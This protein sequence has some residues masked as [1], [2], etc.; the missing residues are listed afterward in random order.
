MIRATVQQKKTHFEAVRSV[1][2][3]WQTVACNWAGRPLL[4]WIVENKVDG[5]RCRT[6]GGRRVTDGGL[7]PTS[8]Q[9]LAGNR[10]WWAVYRLG[11]Q[12][13]GDILRLA[14]LITSPLWLR[15]RLY[16]WLWFWLWLWL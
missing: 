1:C 4:L 10:Q 6:D 8:T 2:I 5:T 9:N 11:S 3:G 14:P 15:L 12:L 13:A 7:R 16:V